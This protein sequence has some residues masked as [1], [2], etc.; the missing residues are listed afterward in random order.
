MS[1]WLP[2]AATAASAASAAAAAAAAA[3]IVQRRAVG[4]HGAGVIPPA[5]EPRRAHAWLELGLGLGL[6]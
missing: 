6:G 5:E 3:G 4:T 1:D 2:A